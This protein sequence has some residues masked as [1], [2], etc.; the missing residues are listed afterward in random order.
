MEDQNIN[1]IP[2]TPRTPTTPSGQVMMPG[3]ILWMIFGIVSVCFCCIGWIPVVGIVYS[4]IGIV[5]GIL[6]FIKGKKLVANF[7]AN[8]ANY[9]PASQKMAKTAKTTGLVGFIVSIAML[10]ISIILTII[11]AGTAVYEHSRF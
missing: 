5:F 8:P 7:D 10:V 4:I 6:A 2:N 9:K 11:A 3:V 1:P